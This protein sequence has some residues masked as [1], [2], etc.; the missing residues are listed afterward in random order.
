MRQYIAL[1]VVVLIAIFLVTQI[2]WNRKPARVSD[3]ASASQAI[4][5]SSKAQSDS[6]DI[7]FRDLRVGG[8]SGVS[9]QQKPGTVFSSPVQFTQTTAATSSPQ[10][11]T[12]TP[13]QAGSRPQGSYSG[14]NVQFSNPDTPNKEAKTLR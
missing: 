14:V 1:S 9:R 10:S 3:Q 4:G 5:Q 13:F 7:G 8:V 6:T 2:E 12:S 11:A